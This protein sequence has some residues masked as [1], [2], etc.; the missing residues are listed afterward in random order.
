MKYSYLILFFLLTRLV[1]AQPSSSYN[2]SFT[3]LAAQWDEAIPLG[4]GQLG[5]LIWKKENTIRLSLDRADLWDERK[6]FE[7]EKHDFGWVQQQLKNKHYEAVQHWGDA[8]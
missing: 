4:N 3:D 8:P 7:I 2:L 1:A 5:A 6:A